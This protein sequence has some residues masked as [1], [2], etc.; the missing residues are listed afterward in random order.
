MIDRG[1]YRNGTL[2]SDN[3]RVLILDE[4]DE[5]LSLGFKDQIY[6]IFQSLP[7]DVQVGLFSATMPPDALKMT[8]KFMTNPIKI[9]VKQDE[10]TLEGIRQF[11]INVEREDNKLITL[12]DLYET[13]SISQAV[14]FRNTKRK[15]DWLTDNLR[16][17]EF[18]VSAIHG[19]AP[20]H[21]REA[22]MNDFRAGSTRVLI[23]TDLLARGIDVHQISLVV[24]YDLPRSLENYIHRIGRSGR[25]GRKGVAINFVTRDDMHTLKDLEKFYHT[26]IEPMPANI[27]DLL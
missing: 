4:A 12:C 3:I 9:L 27:A 21:E 18:E 26:Q 23:T 13:I 1:P 17:K 15:V 24:N 22:I 19:E 10:V 20:P 2:K 16:E 7:T 5:M 6:D 14:I 8:E 25:F 11:F